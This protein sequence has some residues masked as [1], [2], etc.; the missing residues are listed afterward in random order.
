MSD[1]Q[2]VKGTKDIVHPEVALWQHLE[3]AIRD[4]YRRFLYREIRTPL[5][6]Y[7]ELFQ[8]GIGET[9]EVVQKEMYTFLDKGGRSLTLRPENTA[10]VVRAA[11]EHNLF[12]EIFP[13]KFFYIGAM[14]RYDKPQKGRYRQFHQFG[15]EVFADPTPQVD[16]EVIFA[17]VDFL[18]RLGIA[19]IR[20]HLNSVGCSDCR[21]GYLQVLRA[22]AT[23]AGEALCPDCRRKAETNPLRIFDCKNEGCIGVAAS[24]PVVTDHLCAPCRDHFAEVQATLIQMGVLFTPDPRLVRGLDYYTRTAFEV[25]SG[26]LGAQNALLGGGRYNNL[27]RDLGGPDVPGIG[28]AAG[29]ERLVLHLQPPEAGDAILFVAFQSEAQLSTAID[30]ARGMWD[31]GYAALLDYGG[32][33]LKKQFRKA[34]RVG[35][36]F[37]LVVGE[38][39]VLTNQVTVKDMRTQQQQRVAVREL[40][41][42]IRE[43]L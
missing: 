27:V 35:A 11:I 21:P 5:F 23:A 2:A 17:A 41:P 10:S 22:A 1:L 9:S 8:R 14:F 26:Q 16:A 7:S 20:L 28:F 29:M 3:S 18:A 43:H 4:Y 42:W 6:E 19:D 15:V 30:L 12:E 13:L 31:A 33:N 40:L 38:E 24:F 39:E 34:D 25:T 36:R 32:R 37:T